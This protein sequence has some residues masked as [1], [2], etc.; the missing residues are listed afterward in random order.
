LAHTGVSCG[1][2]VWLG[3]AKRA[4]PLATGLEGR[5]IRGMQGSG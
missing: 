4:F 3:V 1:R 5:P 2:G